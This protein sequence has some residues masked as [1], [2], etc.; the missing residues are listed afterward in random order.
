MAPPPPRQWFDLILRVIVAHNPHQSPHP[1]IPP[2]PPQT[3]P[4]GFTQVENV[5]PFSFIGS[6]GICA[7]VDERSIPNFRKLSLSTMHGGSQIY[8]ITTRENIIGVGDET[9]H[10]TQQ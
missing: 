4:V 2:P 1:I 6:V 7:C 8:A 9:M 10:S 5:Y 3:N